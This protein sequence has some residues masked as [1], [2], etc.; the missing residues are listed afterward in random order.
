M[1][2]NGGGAIAYNEHLEHDGPAVFHH[3]CRMGLEGSSRS[4]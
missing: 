4:G 1:L 2:G 3:V